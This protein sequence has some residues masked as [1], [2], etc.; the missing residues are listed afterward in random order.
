MFT[1]IS[2]DLVTI[3]GPGATTISQSHHAWLELP[4]SPN[5]VAWLDVREVNNGSGTVSMG[6][7]TAPRADE[8]LFV[9]ISGPITTVPFAAAVGVTVTPLIKDLLNV[10]MARWF[11]W[12]ITATSSSAWDITFRLFVAAQCLKP[13]HGRQG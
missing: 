9:A 12:Q 13:G 2:Q 4:V 5:A 1:L 3:R 10:P 6:Y 7:Q 11:R 8:S